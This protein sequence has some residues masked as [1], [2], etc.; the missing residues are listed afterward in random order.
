MGFWLGQLQKHGEQN[1]IEIVNPFTAF[2]FSS[3]S[4]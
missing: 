4:A 1:G 2:S 3:L